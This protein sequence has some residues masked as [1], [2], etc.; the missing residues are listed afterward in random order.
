MGPGF[1]SQPNHQSSKGEK[2]QRFSH[3]IF[4]EFD[5]HEQLVYQIILL[6][7]QNTTSPNDGS[8]DKLGI[9]KLRHNVGTCLRQVSMQTAKYQ[10]I[11]NM[12]NAKHSTLLQGCFLCF[13]FFLHL[14]RLFSSQV[15]F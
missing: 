3:L 9:V 12:P 7:I 10:R 4:F 14:P 1:E 2:I 5:I 15:S 11:G 6:K 13:C 8:V